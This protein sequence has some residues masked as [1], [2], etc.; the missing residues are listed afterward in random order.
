MK[1]SH[2]AFICFCLTATLVF[3]L[4]RHDKINAPPKEAPA[5]SS[6]L[7]SNFKHIVFISID[8]LRADH[9]SCYGYPRTTTPFLDNLANKGLR[10]TNAF[11]PISTT[12]P[13]HTS[14]LTGLYPLQHK[15]MKN[16]DRLNDSFTTLP[17]LLQKQGFTTVG[18]SATNVHFKPSNLAQ[19]FAL[20]NE[21]SDEYIQ[22]SV[23]KTGKIYRDAK[24]TIDEA[25]GWINGGKTPDKFFLFI[26]LFDP[27]RIF[28]P[29]TQHLEAVTASVLDPEAMTDFLIAQQHIKPEFYQDRKQLLTTINAYDGEIHFADGELARLFATIQ[30]KGLENETLWIVTSDHGEGLGA[31]MYAEHGRN[32]YN[33]QIHVPLIIYPSSTGAAHEL[34]EIVQNVDLMP[35]I[36]D[37]LDITQDSLIPYP[38]EGVSLQPYMTSE[39]KGIPHE[40]GFAQR[41]AY[42]EKP[43]AN[44]PPK[45]LIEYEEGE[46]FTIFTKQQKLIY[47]TVRGEEMYDI[48][49]DPYETIDLA[50]QHHPMQTL[51]KETMGKKIKELKSDFQIEK[52]TVDKKTIKSLKE[53]GYTQ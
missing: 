2:I 47:N 51:L 37:L 41:R 53:L 40:F 1:K 35:T 8:T 38:L 22:G 9:L 5:S 13:S 16:G 28:S 48:M 20:F 27:H 52:S 18:F 36:A 4:F 39:K 43:G 14:M 7:K 3:I 34:S 17:E 10:F 31:H 33:E 44:A 12:A 45:E 32:I 26:H 29:P 46:K 50:S 25:V 15:V 19:G 11:S 21:P 42:Q 24:D 23:Q 30:A 6:Y 49:T